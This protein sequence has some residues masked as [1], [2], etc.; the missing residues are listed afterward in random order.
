MSVS[1]KQEV[2][3]L[4]NFIDEHFTNMVN[5]RKSK[6]RKKSKNQT[7]IDTIFS[8]NVN[9][10]NEANAAMDTNNTNKDTD[11][12]KDKD[13]DKDSTVPM[14]D[15]DEPMERK[16][17]KEQGCE[18]EQDQ[19]QENQEDYNVQEELDQRERDQEKDQEEKDRGDD[20][21]EINQNQ[22]QNQDQTPSDT[23]FS[24]NVN[25]VDETKTKAVLNANNDNDKSK[26]EDLMV[27]MADKD[28]ETE[29]KQDHEQGCEQDLGKKE[30][31]HDQ[32]HED[33]QVQEE[34]DKRKEDQEK[35]KE[36]KNRAEISCKDKME[37]G[38]SDIGVDEEQDS[39][40]EKKNTDVL[41]GE[42]QS[43][44]SDGD[45]IFHES[46]EFID[47]RQEP[48]TSQIKHK[49]KKK[50]CISS[51]DS[52]TDGST[53]TSDVMN[54]IQNLKKDFFARMDTMTEK[55]FR[56]IDNMEKIHSAEM[57][58]MKTKVNELTAV[59]ENHS[60]E[61]IDVQTASADLNEHF[62][63]VQ[64]RLTRAEK[65]IAD[66]KEEIIDL[67]SQQMKDNLIF[68]G[69]S[70]SRDV[71]EDVEETVMNFLR[72]DMKINEQNLVKVRV[73]T[74]YRMGKRQDS[75]NRVIM[76]RMADT[77]SKS[78]VLQHK[79]NLRNTEYGVNEQ[80]PREV[81][82]RRKHL[83]PLYKKAKQEKIPAK[84][85]HDKVVINSKV[86]ESHKDTITDIN[87]DVLSQASSIHVSR[88][89]PVSYNKSSVQAS[90]VE[91]TCQNDVIP[92]MHAVM[93]Y[94]RVARANHNLYA[95]RIQTGS[96][97]LEHYYDDGEYG[98]GR[99]LLTLMQENNVI[100]KL[101]CISRWH[102]GPNIGE[103]RFKHILDAAR[104]IMDE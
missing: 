97:I 32:D 42:D 31:E 63:L 81:E 73:D 74:C 36:E 88:T 69:I 27:S 48:C 101:I 64:G 78:I 38:A 51:C 59:I 30:Q 77:A 70:E 13:K 6:Q 20:R 24:S 56:R 72:Q 71:N 99:K 8:S 25:K 62:Q 61:L 86:H 65:V 21:G 95:Y 76:A 87:T 44:S 80:K 54:A 50:K 16:Q 17:G 46:M 12:N 66:M 94:E 22:D 89:S 33:H 47:Q 37:A 40:K 39:N 102:S 85:S 1:S 14:T 79:R 18:Q 11:K 93:K 103:S 60:A 7:P 58:E 9:K 10:M 68:Q 57:R 90:K 67:K 92:S 29:C 49:K 15:K 104:S 52:P 23:I 4:E 34:Q 26:D 53:S 19:N 84:W 35:H 75:K 5:P 91:L 3:A 45:N 96:R 41:I 2:Q 43:E 83:L 82:E 100:N 98:A 28:E 55:M